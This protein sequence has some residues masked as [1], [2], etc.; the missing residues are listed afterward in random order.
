V[1]HVRAVD[2][3]GLAEAAGSGGVVLV[4]FWASWCAPCRQ[5]API[6]E[7]IAAARPDAAVVSVDVEAHPE[8]AEQWGVRTIPTYVVRVDGEGSDV[9][10]GAQPKQ[11]LMAAVDAALAAD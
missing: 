6:V 9:L 8:L 2:A 4:D 7:E 10:V 11:T 1:S 5:M 3:P